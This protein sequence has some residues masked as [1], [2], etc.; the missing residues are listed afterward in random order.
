LSARAV[1]LAGLLDAAAS[2]TG[3]FEAPVY[4]DL[5]ADMLLTA[6]KVEKHLGGDA[7]EARHVEELIGKTWTKK[8]RTP[9]TGLTLVE[10]A[11]SS[12]VTADRFMVRESR[13]V[14]L[15]SGGHYSEKQILPATLKTV[16]P[17]KSHAGYV[18]QGAQGNQYPGFAPHRLDLEE[19]TGGAP[20]D[21]AVLERLVEVALP[22]VG[23]VMTAFQE[24]RKDVFAPD[25][26]PV[27]VRVETL[28]A[29]GTRSQFV[30][31]S[32]RGLFLPVDPSLEEPL[33][34]ALEDSRLVAVLG[35][36]GLEAAL[37]TLFP[38]AVVVRTP[39][40]LD[41]RTLGRAEDAPWRPGG[42]A[43]CG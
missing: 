30:D 32:G 11:F 33:S 19:W 26:L 6:R 18:L 38:T 31:G 40:G 7:L 23:A 5:V 8:D 35:D 34:S 27:A 24:H 28:L 37:P 12:K 16:A 4:T 15:V 2:R 14:D 43:A 13:F 21:R 22:D 39:E 3:T 20:V 17:K 1:E 25:L 41:L 36:V 42:A 29:S 9:V 10:Y